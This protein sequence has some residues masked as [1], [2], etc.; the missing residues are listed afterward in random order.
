MASSFSFG[1]KTKRSFVRSFVSPFLPRSRRHRGGVSEEVLERAVEQDKH[2]YEHCG[3][4]EQRICLR[5]VKQYNKSRRHTACL[6]RLSSLTE[7]SEQREAHEQPDEVGTVAVGDGVVVAHARVL[8]VV[9]E[10]VIHLGAQG[11]GRRREREG[12]LSGLA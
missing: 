4:R 2:Q 9:A 1:G 11:K 3:E 10:V 5:D 12:V 7:D 8:G 6:N